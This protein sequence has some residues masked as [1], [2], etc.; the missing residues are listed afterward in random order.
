MYEEVKLEDLVGEHMLSGVDIG[1]TVVKGYGGGQY[2][3]NTLS[4]VPDGDVYIAMEDKNDG[5]RSYMESVMKDSAVVV[6]NTFPPQRVFCHMGDAGSGDTEVLVARDMVMGKGV[7]RVGT[8][9]SHD[10]Y[11]RFVGEFTPENMATNEGK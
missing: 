10:Y 5:Y 4:F 1:T 7:L 2:Y 11:L 6:K 8:N 3:A 9:D